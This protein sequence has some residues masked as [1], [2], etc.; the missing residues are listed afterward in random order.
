V[1]RR[2]RRKYVPIAKRCQPGAGLIEDPGRCHARHALALSA[3]I[4]V[5]AL[6]SGLLVRLAGR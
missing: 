1:V 4:L 6:A 3:L 2:A 5:L